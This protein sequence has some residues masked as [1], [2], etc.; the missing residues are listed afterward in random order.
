MRHTKIVCTIGPA[1]ESIEVLKKML[2]AGMNVARLNFSH[3]NHQEHEARVRAIRQAAE[4]AKKNVGILLDTKGPEI[5]IGEFSQE[6]IFLREG[7]EFTLTTKEVI[8][9]EQIVSIS[10]L[11]LTDDVKTGDTILINDGIIGLSVLETTKDSIRCRVLNDGELSAR[12]GVNVPGVQVNLPA[13]TDK[14]LEDIHFGIKHKFDFIA[15]SFIRTAGDVLEIRRILEE[16]GSDMQIIAKIESRSAVNNIDEILQVADGIMIARGDLGVE[17]PAEEVPL[18]QKSI[19]A[20][21]NLIGK[22]VITAT[23]MLDSMIRNPRPTR[24]EANDVAN[25]I[26]DGT[27]AVMLSG[28]SAN[29]KYPVEAVQ[30]MERI[31]ER[32]EEALD[33]GKIHKKYAP[34]M[35]KTV[36]DSIGHATVH[37]AWE[38]GAAA[39]ITPTT[40]GS[41]ARMVAKY[42]PEVPV[43]A[44]THNLSIMRK[45][46]LVWGVVPILVP[47]TDGTDEMISTAVN[48]AVKSKNI[49]T[50]DLV[51]VTSGIPAGITGTTNLLKVH[52][53]GEAIVK[54]QGIGRKIA[55]G[56]VQ[57]CRSA[58]EAIA[59]INIGDVLVTGSTDKE[60]VSA[61]EKAAAVIT[62]AGGLS[63]HAAIVGLELG[64]PVIVGAQGAMRLLEEGLIITIDSASGLI[65]KG[66]TKVLQ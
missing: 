58:K 37:I 16:A 17:I 60:Y 4:E 30:T 42:R 61:M 47:E 31:A 8:G 65:Y 19:I 55:S 12:K 40:S 3:G 41:T 57:I 28:E 46:T 62:E 39:I 7:Q 64:I 32:T 5:R 49:A 13:V 56:K 63:S 24:A 9:T 66:I 10:Y 45:L 29:G 51:V 50:G 38:L 25:A 11:G 26:L 1:S 34:N 35:Q 44:A 20:K 36:T 59:K 15:P 53:V 48:E 21:C 6:K 18:V 52:V 23:Q 27:D 54:G 33:Y 14:D 2:H 22:P 43:I